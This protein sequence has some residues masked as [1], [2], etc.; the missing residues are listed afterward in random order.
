MGDKF[1]SVYPVLGI[2]LKVQTQYFQV[3]IDASWYILERH[4]YSISTASLGN[5]T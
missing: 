2:V 1:V 5:I 3:S 4:Q